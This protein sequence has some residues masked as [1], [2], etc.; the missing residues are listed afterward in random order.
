MRRR[1]I[2]FTDEDYVHIWKLHI[3]DR[4][5][6]IE[7]AKHVLCS[8]TSVAR[9]ISIFTGVAR[10]SVS[11]EYIKSYAKSA[12]TLKA[13]GRHFNKED[14]VNEILILTKKG[15]SAKFKDNVLTDTHKEDDFNKMNVSVQ[16]LTDTYSQFI[17]ELLRKNNDLLLEIVNLLT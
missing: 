4:M 6:N 14:F 9:T 17:I 7:I 10:S 13:A 2:Y 1:R 3:D 12:A 11:P 5:T 15:G 8:P 16:P